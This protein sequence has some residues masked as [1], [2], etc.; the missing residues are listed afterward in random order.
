M[1]CSPARVLHVQNIVPRHTSFHFPSISRCS[2]FFCE[3]RESLQLQ[4]RPVSL[5]RVASPTPSHLRSR[6]CDRHAIWP[7]PSLFFERIIRM[8]NESWIELHF[9][10][11]AKCSRRAL[12]ARTEA[13]T[14]SDGGR[15]AEAE[16]AMNLHSRFTCTSEVAAA[17][18]EEA[19]AATAAAPGVAPLA[20]SLC[21]SFSS[22]CCVAACAS[23]H[24]GCPPSP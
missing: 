24:C 21:C 7:A 23:V 14:K 18:A 8:Q 9:I 10:C 2:S 11:M 22:L 15:L 3:L 19:A 1:L 16:S 4:K 17:T 5:L 12:C 13:K 6:A 20:S